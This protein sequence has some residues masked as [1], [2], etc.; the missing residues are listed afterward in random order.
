MNELSCI[1]VDKQ[2][3]IKVG[4][5]ILICRSGFAEIAAELYPLIIIAVKSPTL[6]IIIIYQT[7]QQVEQDSIQEYIKFNY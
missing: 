5:P 2:L 3:Y 1:T 4:L 7:L 6:I